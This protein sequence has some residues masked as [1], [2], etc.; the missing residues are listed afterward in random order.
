MYAITDSSFRAISSIND[1]LVGEQMVGEIPA[2]LLLDI[3]GAEV[4][5][6][7]AA[8]L[9]ATDWTQLSDAPLTTDLRGAFDVY[10]Q[11]LRDLPEHPLFPRMPWPT[12]PALDGAAS[13]TGPQT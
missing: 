8:L 13:E 9:R 2:Q 1:L 3:E 12:P 6:K 11:A 10:R 7:R 5:S 4:R